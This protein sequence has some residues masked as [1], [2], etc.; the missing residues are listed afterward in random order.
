MLWISRKSAEPDM[1]RDSPP[2]REALEAF[3]ECV[4]WFERRGFSPPTSYATLFADLLEFLRESQR[5][6]WQG[7]PF[8]FHLPLIARPCEGSGGQSA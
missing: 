4:T 3:T 6:R 1:E 8:N 2:V 7:Q 5:Q